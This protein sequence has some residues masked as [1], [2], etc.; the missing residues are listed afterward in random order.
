MKNPASN[1]KLTPLDDLFKTDKDRAEDHL[2][3]IVLIP[4]SELH[5]FE[6]HP[7]KVQ[8]DDKMAETVDSVKQN[9]VLV[10]GIVRPHSDGGYEIVSGHRRKRACE[11]AGLSDMPVIVRNMDDDTAMILV[12][13]SNL[14]RENLLPSEKAFAYKMKLE[15]I[16]RQAGRP[17]KENP[18]QTV[19]NLESADIL[20]KDTGESGRQ[21]QRYIRLTELITPILEMADRKE[22]PFNAA[23]E[24]SYL[25]VQQQTELI[26]VMEKEQCPP[27]LSQ[28]QHMKKF[29]LEG[30]LNYDV[31]DAIMSGQKEPPIK[32]TLKEEKLR[33]YFPKGYTAEQIEQKIFKILDS[34]HKKQMEQQ[35]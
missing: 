7:F 3:K 11:I 8:D 29:S 24:I 15:A 28:A 4:L 20:G 6:N 17:S 25:N 18:R 14:Q 31:I 16:K 19:G 30:K 27:S 21:V 23:V 9:G 10:P 5:T 35:R 34:W 33:K 2:E 26:D 1:I 22:I 13:D 12:V 32:I